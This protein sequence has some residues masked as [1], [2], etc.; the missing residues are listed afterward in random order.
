MDA[1]I[2]RKIFFKI[3]IRLIFLDKSIIKI[4]EP[5]DT[6]IF[7]LNKNYI[8]DIPKTGSSTL[9]HFASLKSIRYQF[10]IEFLKKHP[11]HLC[12]I[13]EKKIFKIEEDKKIFL[14]IKS[15]EERIFSVYK[16]KVMENKYNQFYS[17]IKINKLFFQYNTKIKFY[18]NKNH[19]FLR[20]CQEI[21]NLKTKLKVNDFNYTDY[22]DKHIISQYDL[23]LNLNKMYPNI[24]EFKMI[25]YPIEKLNYV[26]SKF[27]KKEIN[28][29][30]NPTKMIKNK[31][32]LKDIRKTNL[33]EIVFREDKLLYESLVNSKKGYLEYS[34]NDFADL[35]KKINKFDNY[36][37]KM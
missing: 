28:K 15:P 36:D 20:F 35:R 16:E 13:H 7:K 3:L 8:V 26:L 14:F 11:M 19:T 29:K 2:I 22:F 31:D 6:G 37:K 32:Y 12:T 23:I 24:N 4:I 10:C 17:L 9:K 27:L 34:F 30:F 18:L 21:I 5:K 25:V 1:I 33:N